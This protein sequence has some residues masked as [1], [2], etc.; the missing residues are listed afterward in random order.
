LQ[1][2]KKKT[3]RLLQKSQVAPGARGGRRFPI[4]KKKKRKLPY[5]GGGGNAEGEGGGASRF[6]EKKRRKNA[7]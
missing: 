1:K 4:K 7:R 3:G 6:R 5:A 2:K